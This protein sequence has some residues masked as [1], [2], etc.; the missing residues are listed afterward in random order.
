MRK[1]KQ[2]TITVPKP[3]TA[4]WEQMQPEE[5]GRFC[6]QCQK[7]VV[8]FTGM[9]DAAVF[10]F[11]EKNN[12]APLCGRYTASQLNRPFNAPAARSSFFP[13]AIFSFLLGL[14]VPAVKAVAAVPISWVIEDK[15]KV[16]VDSL[17]ATDDS[18]SL[19][20][21]GRIVDEAG[22][23]IPGATIHLKGMQ[24]QTRSDANGRFEIQLPERVKDK[25]LT[26][27]IQSLGFRTQEKILQR[28]NNNKGYKQVNI[29]MDSLILGD[30]VGG[31]SYIRHRFF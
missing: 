10:D 24:Q 8:D 3:C 22:E 13:V 23:P 15:T 17:P 1:I 6:L 7:T 31:Y 19:K 11:M 29:I 21:T 18:L 30:S 27:I 5:Q 16:A 28:R 9:T 4:E 12:G 26:L 25:N 14:F 20:V 2:C